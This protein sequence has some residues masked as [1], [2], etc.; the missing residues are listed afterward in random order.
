MS[1]RSGK[2]PAYSHGSS[3]DREENDRDR[4]G[5]DDTNEPSRGRTFYGRSSAERDGSY[6]YGSSRRSDEH[7][8]HSSRY[9]GNGEP[10][11][12]RGNDSSRAPKKS[13][14]DQDVSFAGSHFE[15]T[16][17][18]GSR[19]KSREYDDD[20][21]SDVEIDLDASPERSSQSHRQHRKGPWRPM[22]ASG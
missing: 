5:C 11:R 4:S 10:S 1:P 2:K 16:Q 3:R 18:T 17:K 13:Q 22:D 6:T 20:D 21:D 9:N 15:Y 8:S 7:G 19:R 12:R 14:Q